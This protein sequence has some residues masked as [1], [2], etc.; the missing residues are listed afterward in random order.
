MGAA[1]WFG[2]WLG[3]WVV[4]PNME[5]FV[6]LDKFTWNMLIIQVPEGAI[7]TIIMMIFFELAYRPKRRAV[8]L[9][10]V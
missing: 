5:F 10:A 2:T 9:A 1:I 4:I 7:L 3:V 6:G 8:R